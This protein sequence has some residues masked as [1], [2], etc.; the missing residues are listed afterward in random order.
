MYLLHV[1]CDSVRL[2][3]ALV[4]W[5]VYQHFDWFWPLQGWSHK[6]KRKLT[7]YIV[8]SEQRK[9]AKVGHVFVYF[10]LDRCFG[11]ACISDG[12]WIRQSTTPLTMRSARFSRTINGCRR[13]PCNSESEFSPPLNTASYCQ[14]QS[15]DFLGFLYKSP[16]TSIFS[17]RKRSSHQRKKEVLCPNL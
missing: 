6:Q 11:V 16:F 10:V 7:R 2:L 3:S 4:P 9:C 17:W 1:M 14:E 5:Q 8:W 15:C 12:T 13:K